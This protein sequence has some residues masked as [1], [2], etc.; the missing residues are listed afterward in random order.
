MGRLCRLERHGACL[1]PCDLLFYFC[2]LLPHVILLVFSLVS[3]AIDGKNYFN[4]KWLWQ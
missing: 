3:V 2:Q 4:L 1:L